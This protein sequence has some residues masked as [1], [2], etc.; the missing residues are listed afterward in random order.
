VQSS[1]FLLRLAL[2]SMIIVFVGCGEKGPPTGYC[3]GNMTIDGTPPSEN[4]RIIFMDSLHGFNG[5]DTVAKD[6]SYSIKDLRLGEYVIYFEKGGVTVNG[7]KAN[8]EISTDADQLRSV[9]AIYRTE[10]GSP[11][12]KTIIEGKN[13]FE[14]DVPSA[15]KK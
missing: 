12:K 6:G 15:T 1:F 2:F 3:V 7:D 5:S 8:G 9:P 11:L 10:A 13:T 4:V 14:F